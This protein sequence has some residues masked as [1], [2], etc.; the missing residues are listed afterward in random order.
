MINLARCEGNR[1]E[2]ILRGMI[3]LSQVPWGTFP[4]VISIEFFNISFVDLALW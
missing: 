3:V 4:F 2:G 1:A